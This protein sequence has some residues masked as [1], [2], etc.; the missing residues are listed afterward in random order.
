ML[1]RLACAL[2]LA[3]LAPPPRP[4]GSLAEVLFRCPGC[5]AE[6]RAACPVPAAA[7]AEIVREPGCG[8]CPVCARSLGES[9]GVYTPR[10]SGGLRCYPRPDSDMPLEQLVKGLGQCGHKVDAE[11]TAGPENHEQGGDVQ[12][13]KVPFVKHIKDG[14]VQKYLTE[15]KNRMKVSPVEARTPR[16]RTVPQTLCQQ[17]LDQ[18]LEEI[19]KMTFPDNKGP[20]ENLYDL[21]F[22]NCDKRGQ[23][24]L[25]QCHLSTHGQ[26]GECWCVNPHTGVQIE[27]SPRVRGDPNCNQYLNSPE[28]E[29]PTAM[30][31]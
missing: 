11:T 5:T 19:S 4:P 7:C 10:C 17:E 15:K 1:P 28:M 31:K 26:R 3:S 14:A 12:D 21:K 6:R 25:K 20:L 24:N 8:C 13:S 2:L 30:Q 29:L 23:Y 16:P 9:C 18:V 22:P 27:S